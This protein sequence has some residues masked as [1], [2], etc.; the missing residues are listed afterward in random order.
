MKTVEGEGRSEYVLLMAKDQELTTEFAAA[1]SLRPLKTG[2]W[3][4]RN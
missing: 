3:S 1:W 4:K 2:L